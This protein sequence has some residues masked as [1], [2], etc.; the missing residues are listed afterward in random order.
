MNSLHSKALQGKKKKNIWILAILYVRRITYGKNAKTRVFITLKKRD[1][2]QCEFHP[3][4]AFIFYWINDS[5]ECLLLKYSFATPL[6][7]SI[8][9]PHC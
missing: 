2:I 5:E 4:A 6:V 7:P 1:K 3:L 9:L 8:I